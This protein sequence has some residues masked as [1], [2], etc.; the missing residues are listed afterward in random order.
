L[1]AAIDGAVEAYGYAEPSMLNV[2]YIV[3]IQQQGFTDDG[4]GKTSTVHLYK[5]GRMDWVSIIG[6]LRIAT[7]RLEDDAKKGDDDD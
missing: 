3:L 7:L 1:T 5:D 2:Q 4:T 6:L